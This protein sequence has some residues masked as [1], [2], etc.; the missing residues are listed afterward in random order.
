M[1]SRP[2]HTGLGSD[3]AATRFQSGNRK[4][5]R[6]GGRSRQI[7]ASPKAA[8]AIA[9]HV[10]ALTQHLGGPDAVSAIQN[11]LV[12]DYAALSVL[13][14]TVETNVAQSDLSRQRAARELPSGCCCRYGTAACAT[15]RCSACIPPNATS[16]RSTPCDAP[17]KEANQRRLGSSARCFRS[18]TA[19]AGRPG[20]V[21]RMRRW[22]HGLPRRGP[23]HHRG[24]PAASQASLRSLGRR[25]TRCRQEPHRGPARGDFA[26]GRRYK[27]APG[28]RVYVGVFAPTRA[29]AAVT[30]GYIR[31]LIRSVTALTAL[32]VNETK[33]SID[34]SNGVTIEVLTAS[35]A[36]PRSRAYCCAIVE[37]GAF[38]GDDSSA[39]PD[40]ELIRA[41]RP[42]LARVPGSM[43][44]V[45]SS[46]YAKR[47]ELYRVWRE[48][49]G[50]DDEHVLV[51]QAA[52]LLMN[53]T[54]SVAEIERAYRED[55]IAAAAEY[56]AE[57]RDDISDLFAFDISGHVAAGVREIAPNG[58]PT[59]VHWDGAT[60][61][62]GPHA[63]D[64]VAAFAQ[65]NDDGCSVLVALRR[66]RPPFS[67]VSV[68][69]EIAQL[70]A[71]Y[72]V[73]EI[74]GDRLTPNVF[75]D[76]FARHGLD[77]HVAVQD[78]SGQFVELL[79]L[80]NSDRVE[81]LDD[82]DLLKQLRGL[83]RRPRVGG[84]DSVGHRPGQHDDLAAAAAGALLLAAADARVEPLMLAGGATWTAWQADYSPKTHEA[85]PSTC[86]TPDTALFVAAEN[87]GNGS[88]L[89]TF[90]RQ[91]RGEH[92]RLTTAA[93][94]ARIA[95]A[96]VAHANAEEQRRDA[97]A[98]ER[99][100]RN[101]DRLVAAVRQRGSWF[102]GDS[103]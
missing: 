37:E 42:A 75:R 16:T 62:A 49:F 69:A 91:Q 34:L 56:G 14:A 35:A 67:P 40:R 72:G 5:Y 50:V 29:Q 45:V 86:V 48:Q 66:F 12:R 13:I 7:L 30:F 57:F 60:G 39:E 103:L 81:P 99:T 101:A 28:E 92:V 52:T 102:P 20:T 87:E 33:E 24:P 64:A 38:L 15:P 2:L 68:V 51:S 82:A 80:V 6:H 79:A 23:T 27:L 9:V 32:V 71:R 83:E 96:K 98:R 8:A 43:L 95:A 44:L 46:P 17:S 41:L 89:A 18:S 4:A 88:T 58:R 73:G 1:R 36:T 63:D 76:L 26:C 25:W 70:A 77:Y 100:R 31:G 59:Y 85:Q 11:D 10:A 78:T 74:Q 97:E 90:L 19:R 55:P 93:E 65:L 21:L 84:R 22:R 53:P 94:Q 54:F 47:G 3:W 61:S